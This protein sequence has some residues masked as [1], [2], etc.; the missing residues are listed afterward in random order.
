ME[1]I[2][3]ND[4]KILLD[5]MIVIYKADPEKQ[6]WAR[7]LLEKFKTFEADNEKMLAIMKVIDQNAPEFSEQVMKERDDLFY[8]IAHQ[9]FIFLCSL[10][11]AKQSEFQ[12]EYEKEVKTYERQY[13]LN[14]KI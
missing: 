7:Q 9:K 2:L 3:T 1:N 10:N 13:S 4:I 12:K 8:K 5:S 11:P 14:R 6:K